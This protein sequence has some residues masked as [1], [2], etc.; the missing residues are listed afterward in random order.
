M[1][2]GTRKFIVAVTRW[3]LDDLGQHHEARFTEYRLILLNRKRI[4]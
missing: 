1:S 2:Y 4:V 3:P